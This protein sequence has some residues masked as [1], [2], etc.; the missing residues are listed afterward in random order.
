MRVGAKRK[1][2]LFLRRGYRMVM[3]FIEFLEL[4]GFSGFSVQRSVYGVC[5]RMPDGSFGFWHF[6]VLVRNVSKVHLKLYHEAHEGTRRFV[7]DGFLRALRERRGES[8]LTGLL[9]VI[10]V[11]LK[12]IIPQSR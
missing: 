1:S 12:Q 6:S 5:F 2:R 8:C 3:E 4:I 11:R 7:P 9:A 10:R